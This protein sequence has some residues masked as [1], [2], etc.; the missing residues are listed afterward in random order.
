MLPIFEAGGEHIDQSRCAQ[1]APKFIEVYQSLSKFFVNFVVACPS[2]M[3]TAMVA[4]QR[5][6]K[7][8]GGMH[9]ELI[10]R[11]RVD[12]CLSRGQ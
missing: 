4:A 2:C 3:H 1:H 6:G 12:P 11:V 9:H 8:R 5:P 7:A 10:K